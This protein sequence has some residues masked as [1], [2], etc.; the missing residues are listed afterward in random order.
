VAEVRQNYIKQHFSMRD[1]PITQALKVELDRDVVSPPHGLVLASSDE[2][3]GSGA[4]IRRNTLRG[5]HVRG[6]IVKADN[7]LVEE[8]RFEGIGAN[9]VL[10]FPELHFLEG[11]MPEG[12]TIRGNTISHCGWK[13]LSPRSA[14]PG[15]GGAIQVCVGMARRGFPPQFDPYPVIRNITI[16]DNTIKDSG[17]YG[18]VMGNVAKG[19]ITNNKIEYPFNKP[20]SRESK[21]LARAFDSKDH[22]LEVPASPGVS[23]AGILVYGSRDI[24]LSG[25]KV[26]PTPESG[27]VKSILV[28]P[29]CEGVENSDPR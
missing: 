3:C 25:N 22:P 26:T 8:N 24:A 28:G 6:V 20:G 18:I 21:G 23:P 1:L 5:G 11:P 4:V 9:A 12:I 29:W 27:G 17:S 10:V 19:S 13:V 16:A 14:V 7:V 15:V 2:Q